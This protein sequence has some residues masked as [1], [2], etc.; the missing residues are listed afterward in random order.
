MDHMLTSSVKHIGQQTPSA[1]QQ[2]GLRGCPLALSPGCQASASV[3]LQ[4]FCGNNKIQCYL[5]GVS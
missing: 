2:H 4:F 1:S 3:L 5:A